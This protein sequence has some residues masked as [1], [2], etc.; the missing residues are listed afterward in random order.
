MKTGCD[1]MDN[2]SN[3]FTSVS[4]TM[5]SGEM[6]RNFHRCSGALYPVPKI[7]HWFLR[8]SLLF[9]LFSRDLMTLVLICIQCG[10]GNKTL[11]TRYRQKQIKVGH[12]CSGVDL[13]TPWV[14]TKL[15]ELRKVIGTSN[16]NH[17]NQRHGN[18]TCV[19]C[20]TLTQ[21]LEVITLY[22]LRRSRRGRS[23]KNRTCFHLM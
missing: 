12:F 6:F 17:Q 20:F 2:L 8:L 3:V 22:K 13:G 4:K 18:H 23:G 21:C 15:V 7:C 10:P 19:P 14:S 9:E 1:S 11:S 16:R 5:S